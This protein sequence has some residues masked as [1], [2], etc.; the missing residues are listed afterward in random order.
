MLMLFMLAVLL[1]RMRNLAKCCPFRV[2]WWA[3]SF[4]LTASASA[5]IRYAG[6]APHIAMSATALSILGMASF[7]IAVLALRTLLGLVQGDWRRLNS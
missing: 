6:H 2:S 3:V 5:A 7:I 1:G 4:P